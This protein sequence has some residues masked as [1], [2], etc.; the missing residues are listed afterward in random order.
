MC[1][2]PSSSCASSNFGV[3]ICHPAAFHPSYVLCCVSQLRFIQLW[4]CDLLSSCVSSKVCADV[5]S[6]CCAPSSIYVSFMFY[7][8]SCMCFSFKCCGSSASYALTK[9]C[10]VFR[11]PTAFHPSFMPVHPA[12]FHSSIVPLHLYA[13]H[14]SIVSSTYIS[15]KFSFIHRRF[16]QVLFH[17]PAFQ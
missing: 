16:S 14:P 13:F 9:F 3:V 15:A 4:C 10:V 1:C 7:V 8:L 17:P 12:A 2:V 11:D 5:S 6:E